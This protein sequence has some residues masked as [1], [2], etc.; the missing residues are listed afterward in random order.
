MDGVDQINLDFGPLDGEN[1]ENLKK[2]C[3]QAKNFDNLLAK[4]NE[5]MMQN[6]TLK[7]YYDKLKLE[8]KL[9]KPDFIY[10]YDKELMESRAANFPLVFLK[11]HS[12]EM[13]KLLSTAKLQS[14]DGLIIKARSFSE[15]QEL[16]KTVKSHAG[17]KKLDVQA[18]VETHSLTEVKDL[19][20]LGYSKVQVPGSQ[21]FKKV[22]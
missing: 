13:L 11:V 17:L 4:I 2:Y 21:L 10:I 6:F 18:E 20:A 16:Y 15:A 9:G 19:K 8:G 12:P 22:N 14:I 1:F 5:D 3:F 7:L